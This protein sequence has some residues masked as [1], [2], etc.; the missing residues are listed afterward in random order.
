MIQGPLTNTYDTYIYNQSKRII[1]VCFFANHRDVPAMNLVSYTILI[2]SL[3]ATINNIIYQTKH[4]PCRSEMIT[5]ETI[6]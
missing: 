6:V 5:L 2:L 4:V 1:F 3:A